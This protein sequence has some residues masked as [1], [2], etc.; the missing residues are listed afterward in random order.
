[1][2]GNSA[3]KAF[4]AFQSEVE[5]VLKDS[6]NPHYGSTYASL[7][8]I[9]D[10][11]RP[12]LA[13]H[14]LAIMQTAQATATD[15]TLQTTVVHESGETLDGGSYPLRPVKNDPQGYGSAMTYARRYTLAALCGIAQEDDDGNLA[16][17]PVQTPRQTAPAAPRPTKPA[18]GPVAA[19]LPP[20]DT[21][22]EA[23]EMDE[24][25][26][27]TPLDDDATRQPAEKYDFKSKPKGAVLAGWENKQK[28][29]C[30]VEDMTASQLVEAHLTL[31]NQ[32]EWETANGKE[33]KWTDKDMVAVEVEMRKRGMQI[34]TY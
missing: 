21:R 9:L 6:K 10:T 16:S 27:N 28:F 17:K 3:A 23:A 11:I 34:P 1:M 14:K 13:K 18:R 32:A 31:T 4:V 15:T 20:Q 25:I 8:A 22:D 7:A 24:R 5:N 19:S 33:T 12:I 29:W 2:A 26:N 30:V